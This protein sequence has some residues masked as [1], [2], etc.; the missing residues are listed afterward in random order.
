MTDKTEP[1]DFIGVNK[2]VLRPKTKEEDF[3]KLM[4]EE[5]FHIP[6]ADMVFRDSSRVG[7][8]KLYRMTGEGDGREYL[9]TTSYFRSDSVGSRLEA[10][11]MHFDQLCAEAQKKIKKFGKLTPLGIL[12][13]AEGA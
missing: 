3:E 1:L 11:Q 2:I 12:S 13:V 5:V 10:A 4:K 9:W 7:D 6:V 8:N